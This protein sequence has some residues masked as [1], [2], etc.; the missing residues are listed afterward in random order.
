MIRRNITRPRGAYLSA[1]PVLN[2]TFGSPSSDT[3]G[4]ESASAADVREWPPSSRERADRY[5]CRH[6]PLTEQTEED[7]VRK[8]AA[9]S[10]VLALVSVESSPRRST[11]RRGRHGSEQGGRRG[12]EPPALAPD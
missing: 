11:A 4:G 5:T 9:F 8:L 12:G 2:R 10:M 3:E 6:Q 1:L 7:T